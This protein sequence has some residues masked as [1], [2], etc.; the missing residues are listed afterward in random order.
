MKIYTIEFDDDIK[1][2]VWMK[3]YWH[4]KDKAFVSKEKVIN[5][6][7]EMDIF[8]IDGYKQDRWNDDDP[9]VELV[10]FDVHKSVKDWHGRIVIKYMWCNTSIMDP[11]EL[12]N[13][14]KNE[15]LANY[16]MMLDN[17]RSSEIETHER[18]L[19]ES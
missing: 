18:E 7:N 6:I 16:I 13:D 14:F 3:F 19:E 4:L 11:N 17:Y 8:S 15:K 5:C 9:I 12:R 10:I 1:S 2:G